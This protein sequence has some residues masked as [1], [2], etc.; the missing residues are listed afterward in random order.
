M[1]EHG[2]LTVFL[3]VLY[4]YRALDKLCA[5]SIYLA[6]KSAAGHRQVHIQALFRTL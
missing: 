3:I 1:S 4:E 2:T 5:V 6:M